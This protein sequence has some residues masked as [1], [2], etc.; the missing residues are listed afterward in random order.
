MSHFT[1]VNARHT[2]GLAAYRAGLTLKELITTAEEIDLM[3]E[4]VQPGENAHAEHQEIAN[5]GPS[6]I[7]G[8]ADG[9]L[10]DIRKLANSTNLTRRGQSA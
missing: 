4:Q 9:L 3:H 8:F 7:A 6:L 2:Q 5:A 1:L 10:D